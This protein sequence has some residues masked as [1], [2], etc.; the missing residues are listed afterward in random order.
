MIARERHNAKARQ[1]TAG[2]SRKKGKKPAKTHNPA[3][4]ADLPDSNAEVHVSKTKEQKEDERKEKMRL[5]LAEQ[6][7]SKMNTKKRKRLDKYIVSAEARGFLH[8][9]NMVPKY[10][11]RN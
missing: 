3:V 10:R 2:G 9:F 8:I 7:N 6:S 11:T 5:E 4:V 1:S